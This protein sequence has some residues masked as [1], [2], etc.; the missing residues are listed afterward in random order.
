M[1][2]LEPQ[3]P[4]LSGWSAGSAHDELKAKNQVNAQD[5]LPR[6]CSRDHIG[7]Y[8]GASKFIA[9]GWADLGQATSYN[10]TGSKGDRQWVSAKGVAISRTVLSARRSEPLVGTYCTNYP[11]RPRKI[12]AGYAQHPQPRGIEHHGA[13]DSAHKDS[14]DFEEIIGLLLISSLGGFAIFFL[15]A[16]TAYW[17]CHQESSEFVVNVR[18]LT[19]REREVT[20]LI[21]QASP[22]K[23]LAELLASPRAPL[24]STPTPFT[25]SSAFEAAVSW[26]VCLQ[27]RASQNLLKHTDW[28][29]CV[30]LSQG[31]DFSWI[32]GNGD[33]SALQF[34]FDEHP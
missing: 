26:A 10:R 31:S 28:H 12:E 21:A 20:S 14:M 1:N 23:P 25:R 18:A 7:R 34:I 6:H 17:W 9:S 3:E 4:R 24:S 5:H 29:Y 11:G 27:V 15:Y 19:Q 16:A 33:Y 2:Y 13:A 8:C 32:E 30:T 22:T